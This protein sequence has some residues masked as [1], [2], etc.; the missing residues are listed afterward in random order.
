MA[1]KHEQSA[2]VVRLK[3]VLTMLRAKITSQKSL[4][5]CF[6]SFDRDKDGYIDFEEFRNVLLTLNLNLD[7]EDCMA[8]SL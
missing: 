4:R 6:R 2:Y 5:D 7:D 3:K 1:N 8:W